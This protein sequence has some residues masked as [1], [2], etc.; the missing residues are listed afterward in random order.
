MRLFG[1]NI[2]FYNPRK[3]TPF[4]YGINHFVCRDSVCKPFAN[5]DVQ[6]VLMMISNRMRN[7]VYD[8][9]V[10]YL[11]TESIFRFLNENVLNIIIKMFYDGFVEIDMSEP[12]S[13][14]FSENS[15]CRE[16]RDDEVIVR[17]YDEV[18]ITT[19]KTRALTLAPQIEFIDVIND[20]DLNLIKNYGAMGVLSPESSTHADGF[21][22]DKDRKE[23]QEE[24]RKS[25]GVTFGKWA[26][27][28][29]RQPV[30]YQPIDLPIKQLEL[31]EKRKVA[32][33]EIL[34]YMNIPKE[35]HAFFESAK[36]VNRNEAELDMYGNTISAWAS[37]F[38]EMASKMYQCVRLTDRN[39]I[40]YVSDNEF[41]FDIVGVPALQ[42]AQYREKQKAREEL[43][44]WKELKA[45][46]PEKADIINKRIESII[47][48]L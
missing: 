30:K 19:G 32:I 48:N 40:G 21:I 39:G 25:Y 29:S 33:A 26:I 6:S 20:S 35:L 17:V 2:S 18:Y 44:M 15:D 45:E 46:M 36:Y 43:E 9:D 28:I 42:E 12:L 1:W 3:H 5:A 11:A 41:W 23:M 37:L 47:E 7:V 34:Q 14:V 24:Y 16:W 38:T 10:K 22:D 31:N 8:C 4:L 13:P 27:F